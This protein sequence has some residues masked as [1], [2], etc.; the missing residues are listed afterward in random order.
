MQNTFVLYTNY[1]DILKD[2]PLEDLGLIFKAIMH[3]KK[4]NAVIDLPERLKLGFGFI[5][6]QMDVDSEK[7][8]NKVAKLA[9]NGRKGG[10]AKSAKKEAVLEE[11]E[12]AAEQEAEEIPIITEDEIV[13]DTVVNSLPI[14]TIIPHKSFVPNS[15]RGNEVSD[16]ERDILEKYVRKKKLATKNVGAYVS[17]IISNGDHIRILKEMRD[18]QIPPKS[19]KEKIAE[20]LARI[21]DKRSCAKELCRYYAVG[22]FPPVE[23]DEIA[24]KYGLECYD[25]VYEYSIE[26]SKQAKGG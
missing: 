19:E 21:V 13:S 6:N 14:E 2:S 24:E 20:S 15:V 16:D 7:Y 23:Y 26:L 10:L 9:Q 12:A 25:D 11:F 22:D 18:K 17:K 1:Y 4:F 3:Y 8:D 5:K